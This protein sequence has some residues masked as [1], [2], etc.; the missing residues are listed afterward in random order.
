MALFL[1]QSVTVPDR[2]VARTISE[3]CGVTLATSTYQNWR[4]LAAR[5]LAG[6]LD[7]IRAGV[8]CEPVVCADETPIRVN[9]AVAYLHVAASEKFSLFH[10]AGR[11]GA[12]CRAGGVVGTFTGTLVSD[13]YS[14]YWTDKGPAHQRCSAHL[15]RD[16]Q[17][18]I[19]DFC[20]V[21]SDSAAW[22]RE[23]QKLV[24][25]TKAKLDV[26]KGGVLTP[27][28]YV[29]ARNAMVRLA[30]T[31]L[32][33]HPEPAHKTVSRYAIN[34][35]ARAL[36]NRIVKHIDEYLTYTRDPGVP[37]TNNL[38]EQAVRHAKVRQRRSGTHRALSAAHEYAAIRSYLETGRK[39]GL[40]AAR[41]L[42]DLAAG[43]PWVPEVA[44][45]LTR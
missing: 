43:R 20:G 37:F 9:G 2:W 6:A 21:T 29:L 27:R 22:A 3:L 18:V 11:T 8:L 35:N 4:K 7:V 19:D 33:T 34:A 41:I 16:L 25:D 1:G 31:G 30:H 40:E 15:L 28:Q 45:A 24:S 12:D 13:C 23:L 36:A 5:D 42:E 26:T 14:A 44:A 32:E 17:R 39:H 38:A 10:V